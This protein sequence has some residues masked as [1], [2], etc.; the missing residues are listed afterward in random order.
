MSRENAKPI[1]FFDS[2]MGDEAVPGEAAATWF[3][4]FLARLRDKM[5]MIDSLRDALPDLVIMLKRDGVILSHMGGCG[6]AALALPREAAGQRLDSIWPEST[7]LCLKQ[8]VRHAIAQR[9]TL[10]TSFTAAEVRYEMR[11]TP[12]GPD[13]A[14]CVIR[15]AARDGRGCRPR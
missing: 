15:A 7:A 8:A 2:G 13:R 10:D 11:T 12:Q 1:S 14:L 5:R 4:E 3:R 6:V 9:A